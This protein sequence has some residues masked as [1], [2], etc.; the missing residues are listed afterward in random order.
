[1]VRAAAS[2]PALASTPGRAEPGPPAPPGTPLSWNR[3]SLANGLTVIVHEDRREPRV[4]VSMTYRVGSKDEAAG[5]WGFAHLFEHLMFSGSRH[6]PGAYLDVMRR[7]GALDVN[8]ATSRDVTHYHQLVPTG[9]LDFVLFAEADRMTDVLLDDELLQRQREIVMMEKREREG[10]PLGRRDLCVARGL[11]PAGHPYGHTVIGDTADLRNA[12]LAD[13]REWYGTFYT[14]SNAVLVLVGDVNVDAARTAAQTYFAA[15]APGPPLRRPVAWVEPRRGRHLDIIEDRL[16]HGMLSMSWVTPEG[17]AP[18]A[19]RMA[20]AAGLLTEGH[21]SVLERALVADG[22]PASAVTVS[23]RSDELCGELTL[24]ITLRA[25]DAAAEAQRRLRQAVLRFLDAPPDEALFATLRQRHLQDLQRA[26]LSLAGTAFLLVTGEVQHGDPGAADRVLTSLAGLRSEEVLEAASCWLNHEPYLLHVRPFGDLRA[27]TG[28]RVSI[29]PPVQAT[30]APAAVLNYSAHRSSSGLTLIAAPAAADG[31]AVRLLLDRG[32]ADLAPADGAIAELLCEL[33]GSQVGERDRA[34]SARWL[35]EAQLQLRVAQD[36]GAL[37]V[38][39]AAPVPTAW[40]DVIA[41]LK[42][43]LSW[44]APVNASA[45]RETF[46]RARQRLRL[47]YAQLQDDPH[48]IAADLPHAA[49]LGAEHP[50]LI[51]PRARHDALA[52]ATFDEVRRVYGLLFDTRL[53]TLIVAGAPAGETLAALAAAVEGGPAARRGGAPM[54]RRHLPPVAQP[55]PSVVPVVDAGSAGQTQLIGVC[56]LP[57]FNATDEWAFQAACHCLGGSF[58]SRL[59]QRLREVLQATYGVS[60]RLVEAGHPGEPRRM[61]IRTLVAPEQ[62][63]ACLADIRAMLADM[64]E[65]VPVSPDELNAFRAEALQKL[66]TFRREP[67][68]L[69]SALDR[70]CRWALSEN[71]W[72][73]RVENLQSLSL[74]AVRAVARDYLDPGRFRWSAAGAGAELC[75]RLRASGIRAALHG[76]AA[77]TPLLPL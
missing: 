66:P 59:S 32:Y 65:T 9:M 21:P 34:E 45:A 76:A 12:T 68:E 30:P 33:C 15:I 52:H 44:P 67:L 4:H 53:A 55:A 22:G 28:A 41:L 74:E 11:Y 39:I 70:R 43:I 64:A 56:L 6:L 1:M 77:D 14:P 57:P 8:G 27:S 54:P 13:A 48:R 7:A 29:P 60:S 23:L 17:R 19:E 3:F 72:V 31:I 40:P 18:A 71:Y 46:D 42:S 61:V 35:T 24:S 26:R 73:E 38:D 62:A 63:A 16:E 51:S 20:L 2:P 10:A 58:A 36:A 75:A 50:L 5:Q 69:V 47:R 37:S 49:L 25:S